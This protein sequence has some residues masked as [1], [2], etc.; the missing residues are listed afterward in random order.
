MVVHLSGELQV[1]TDHYKIK[2]KGKS[3]MLQYLKSRLP[4]PE[5]VAPVNKKTKRTKPLTSSNSKKTKS[6]H[7]DIILNNKFSALDNGTDTDTPATTLNDS[8]HANEIEIPK[9][10]NDIQVDDEFPSLNGSMKINDSKKR[11]YIPPIVVDKVN[12][13]KKLM[14]ELNALT[15]EKVTARVVGDKLKIFPQSVKAHRLIRSEITDRRKLQAHTFLLPQDKQLKIVIRGLPH[16][17]PTAELV[18]DLRNESFHM[19]Y[20]IQLKHRGGKD[21]EAVHRES[22]RRFRRSF[23]EQRVHISCYIRETESCLES[24]SSVNTRHLHM[25]IEFIL[26]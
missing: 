7:N 14:D 17:Y 22:L 18:E 25:L 10:I 11:P 2:R 5:S 21:S 6:S 12:N 13:D 19:E 1:L 26:F 8:D 20:A 16:D 23:Q 3:Q 15:N 24:S 4:P 9:A